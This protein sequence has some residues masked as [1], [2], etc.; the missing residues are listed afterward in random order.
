MKSLT[1]K[2]RV[3][4]EICSGNIRCNRNII[5]RCDSKQG[6]DIWIMR[7]CLKRIPEEDNNIN[8]SF[9]NLSTDLQVSP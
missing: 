8:F 5:K 2:I 9:C 4:D 7:L 6:F 1:E 3:K